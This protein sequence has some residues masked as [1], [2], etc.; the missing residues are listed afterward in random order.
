MGDKRREQRL[1]LDWSAASQ[2]PGVGRACAAS[3]HRA[4]TALLDYQPCGGTEAHRRGGGPSTRE[5]E[6]DRDAQY[7]VTRAKIR[8]IAAICTCGYR[9]VAQEPTRDLEREGTSSD[10]HPRR[11]IAHG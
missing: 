6:I 4:R 8:P 5:R 2:Y 11:R 7:G 9:P 10:A 3:P 1:P